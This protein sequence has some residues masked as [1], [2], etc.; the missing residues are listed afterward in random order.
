M[1]F[2]L[3]MDKKNLNNPYPIFKITHYHN[4][5][6]L[7]NKTEIPFNVILFT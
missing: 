6:T 5:I 4:Q 1:I 3:T 7:G 2:P